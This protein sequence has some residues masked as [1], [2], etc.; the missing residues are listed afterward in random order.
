MND[1]AA[2]V[3]ASISIEKAQSMEGLGSR[4]YHLEL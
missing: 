2:L 4:L 3:I 1:I